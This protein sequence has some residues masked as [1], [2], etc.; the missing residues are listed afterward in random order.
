MNERHDWKM[1]KPWKMKRI[2]P[3]TPLTHY[4]MIIFLKI[5]EKQYVN[6]N[7]YGKKTKTSYQ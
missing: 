4:A 3:S 7:K 2:A 6:I 5:W 1:T